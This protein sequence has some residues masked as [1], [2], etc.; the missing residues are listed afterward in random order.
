MDDA[1]R[2]RMSR[3]Y[4]AIGVTEEKDSKKLKAT[5]IENVGFKAH[6]QDFR[7]CLSDE[8]L[9]NQI[10][11]VIHNIANLADH[12]RR[13]AAKNGR[14]KQR[15]N[16]ILRSSFELQ[17]IQDL[18]DNDKHGYPPRDGGRSG[19]SPQLAEI[20]RVMCL[21]PQANNGSVI[22]MTIGAGGVPKFMG[23]VSA[24]AVV[25]SR[26]V[27]YDNNY[28]CEFSDITAKAVEAWETLLLE[29]GLI[30]G[31]SGT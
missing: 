3:I 13:W 30:E 10:H 19:K 15:V 20:D 17:V 31:I 29:F 2:Q 8:E 11:L 12:L 1:I 14:D 18:S 26:I 28:L 22:A 24:K 5:V 6:V 9:S 4:S 23:D 25:I 7:G 21:Q 27:D 16:Q